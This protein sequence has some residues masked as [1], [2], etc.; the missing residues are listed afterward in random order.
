MSSDFTVADRMYIACGFSDLRRGIDSLASLVQ[1]QFRL[2]LFTNTP[3]L[4][5]GGA[6]CEPA[7]GSQAG[8]SQGIA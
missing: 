7:K 8:K 4:T 5:H 3:M 1:Q 6:E 2:N